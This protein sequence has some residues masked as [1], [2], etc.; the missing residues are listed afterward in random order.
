VRDV[1]KQPVKR[2]PAVPPP[3]FGRVNDDSVV[4]RDLYVIDSETSEEMVLPHSFPE[5]VSSAIDD[6]VGLCR[7]FLNFVFVCFVAAK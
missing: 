6:W 1:K 3:L 2:R 7:V 5:H 4:M